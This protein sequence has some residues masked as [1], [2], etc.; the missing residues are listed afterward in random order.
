MGRPKSTRAAE[1]V[2]APFVGTKD[3]AVM[4]GVSVSTVQKLVESGALEAWRTEGGHRRIPLASVE[5][6]LAGRL[7]PPV[8][9]AR[10]LRV[11]V[12]EDSAV[13]RAAYAQ[14]FQRQGHSIQV[15]YAADG[16]EALLLL[17]QITPEV[18]ITDLVMKPIDGRLLIK[19]VRANAKTKHL[20]IVIVSGFLEELG[21]L[22]GLDARTV[23]YA[24]PLQF[25]RLAGYLDAQIQELSIASNR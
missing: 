13:I 1:A 8:A 5:K 14:M 11:L 18:L 25:E 22:D 16:A 24:K 4:L 9:Y 7:D 2:E 12:V 23:A 10:P 17:A 3:A 21:V 20:R 19:T 6:S 15:T